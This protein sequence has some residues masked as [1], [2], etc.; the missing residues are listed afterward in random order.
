MI[1][2][3][4]T[5]CSKK[6]EQPNNNQ[7]TEQAPASEQFHALTKT[8]ASQVMAEEPTVVSTP[9]AS[10]E[11]HSTHHKDHASA[12]ET[13]TSSQT[14][15]E[16]EHQETAHTSTTIHRE[17]KEKT[18]QTEQPSTIQPVKVQTVSTD[19]IKPKHTQENKASKS[20]L[21]ED[22]AVAAAM[23]AA[24]PALAN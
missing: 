19:S 8:E 16:N 24:Q 12:K 22:D 23:S 4:L 6:E 10:S 14:L 5:A 13:K 7:S 15:P 18:A 20:N 2:L 1:G 11:P 3:I 21:T 17:Y 9:V